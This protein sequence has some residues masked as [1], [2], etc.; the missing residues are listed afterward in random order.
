M[1]QYRRNYVEGGT[2]FFTVVTFMRYP[3]LND[4]SI[5]ILHEALRDCMLTKT[6]DLEAMVILPDHIHSIWQ[7]PLT[8]DDY[9]SRWKLIKAAFTKEYIRRVGEAKRNPRIV[10]GALAKP[11]R[12]GRA[13]EAPAKPTISMQK[14]GEKGIWQRRFWEH[15]IRDGR[16]YSM[17]CDY[18]H[19]NP[20]KHG[21]VKSPRNWPYSTFQEF[22]Q[23]GIYP[24]SWGGPAEG[25]PEG[26][27]GE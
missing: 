14:K 1:P 9:S 10:G 13:G 18:I 4:L 20:V 22:V 6:F 24:E 8:D 23:R 25:F 26:M 12:T 7:L 16:D 2:Y 11:T 5:P 3:L 21:L 15:T 27:G 17:H 19:Y